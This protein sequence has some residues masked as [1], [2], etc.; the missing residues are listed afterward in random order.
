MPDYLLTD[1]DNTLWDTNGVF[2]A[3]QLSLLDSLESLTKSKVQVDDRLLYVRRFDQEIAQKHPDG[4]RYPI[5]ELIFALIQDIG[6]KNA[7]P[8]EE[9][10]IDRVR[11]DYYDR[12]KDRPRLRWGVRKTIE[13]LA[14]AGT[15]IWV[16]SEGAERRVREALEEHGLDSFVERVISGKKTAE[17][18][19][20]LASEIPR[21]KTA[22]VVGD[23]L[24]RDIVPAKA[25]GFQ[26]AYFPGGFE[27][28]WIELGHR[29]SVDIHISN[30][31]Q[32]LEIFWPELAA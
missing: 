22:L 29:E 21:R 24:D 4:L 7:L 32:V 10:A 17:F 28:A 13:K 30:F 14:S 27:P 9:D 16:V 1:A 12:L 5:D 26:T 25:A 15:P 6:S 23:Q 3:A 2:A 31:G 18:F 19:R 11:R 20:V 8:L